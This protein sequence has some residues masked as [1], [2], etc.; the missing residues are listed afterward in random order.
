MTWYAYTK[1][2]HDGTDMSWYAKREG[3][4]DASYVNRMYRGC[5]ISGWV[6]D[7]LACIKRG[8]TGW[9]GR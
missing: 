6:V 3:L 1:G 9:V 5:G 2:L 8:I 4:N 7:E